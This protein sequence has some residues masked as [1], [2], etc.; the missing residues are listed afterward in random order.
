M[1]KASVL[2][3]LVGAFLISG[4]AARSVRIA[5]LRDRPTKYDNKTVSVTGT[6]TSSWGIPLVPFKLY[7][8]DDGTGEITIV[9]NSSRTPTKGERIRVKGKVGEVAQFG[10]TSIGLHLQE[11]GRSYKGE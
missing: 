1:R 4:C 9:S 10:G 3:A 6:V 11:T 5:E 2:V 8:V 7:K